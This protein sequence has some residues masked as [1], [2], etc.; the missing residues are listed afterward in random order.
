MVGRVRG[1]MDREGAI[2]QATGGARTRG[3]VPGGARGE[4]VT[5]GRH[6]TRWCCGAGHTTAVAAVGGST[7]AATA[8]AAG[9][10]GRWAWA[11]CFDDPSASPA[12][13]EQRMCAGPKPPTKA[14]CPRS[15]C[16]ASA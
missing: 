10:Q 5:S 13:G 8:W 11:G 14:A 1:L 9:Q 15:A 7:G 12:S 4:A 16:K 3:R 6:E 2:D